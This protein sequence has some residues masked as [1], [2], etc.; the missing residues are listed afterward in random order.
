VHSYHVTETPGVLEKYKQASSQLLVALGAMVYPAL[1]EDAPNTAG[2]YPVE[3]DV[4]AGTPS[5]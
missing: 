5:A 1:R 3:Y 4:G 2:Q